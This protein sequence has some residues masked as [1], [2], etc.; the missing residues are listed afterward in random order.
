[1]RT[2]HYKIT[3][4]LI[5]LGAGFVWANSLKHIKSSFNSVQIKPCLLHQVPVIQAEFVKLIGSSKESFIM[6][7]VV[8]NTG[9]TLPKRLLRGMHRVQIQKKQGVITITAQPAGQAT[10]DPILGMGS[11]PSK[12][13]LR[14]GSE[15]HDRLIYSGQ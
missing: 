10:P 3:V 1:M 12:Q 2:L 5:A 14:T 4:K 15:Q 7:A 9:L 13:A 11:S 6:E 8:S